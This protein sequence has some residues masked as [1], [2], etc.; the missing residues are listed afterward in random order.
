[1]KDLVCQNYCIRQLRDLAAS[2]RHSIMI[3]GPKGS[4][5]TYLARM[6]KD[7]LGVNAFALVSPNVQAIRDAMNDCSS[8]S[9][10]VVLCIEN[11]DQGVL[12]ASYTLLKF[13]EE[14]SDN[15]YIVVTCRSQYKVP[16]TIVSRS[17]VTTITLPTRK[18]L[19]TYC[20]CEYPSEYMSRQSRS[21]FRLVNTFSDVDRIM[22][23]SSDQLDYFDS[24]LKIDFSEPVSSMSW[25]LGHYPDNSEAP[26]DL[27]IRQIM[28]ITH[29][30]HVRKCGINCLNDLSSSRLASHAVLAKFCMDMK[31]TE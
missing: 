30:Q 15:V 8:G 31:Y 10:E 23:M 28:S 13:L 24:L 29:N 20:I 9:D 12:G 25:K 7:L 18:D 14:P 11:L 21:V 26:V 4:G 17:T 22:S 19:E 5:K 2:K 6:Y 27:V 16:D 1:M 3:E